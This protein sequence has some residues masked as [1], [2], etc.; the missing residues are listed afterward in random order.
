M[1]DQFT[2]PNGTAQ[3]VL[4]S[5]QVSWVNGV[6]TSKSAS[7]N[8]F[9]FTHKGLITENHTDTLFGANPAAAPALQNQFMSSL[10]NNGVHYLF[11][12]HDHIDN[13]AVITSPDGLSKVQ[14]ITAASNSYK[15]YVPQ[16]GANINDVKYDSPTRETPISQQM[17]TV[18]Y[19]LVNVDGPKVTVDFYSSPNG[20]N[21][22]CDLK[23][24][25][26]NLT[27]TKQETFG[28]SL[29]GKEFLVAAGASYTGINDSIAAGNGFLGTAMSFTAGVNGNNVN[30]YD[31]RGTVADVNTGWTSKGELGDAALRSDQLTMWGVSDLSNTSA[32][33]VTLE[34][35][36]TGDGPV[37]LMRKVNG[38]WQ[39]A[40]TGMGFD[41]AT[42]KAWANVSLSAIESGNFA[43]AAVPEP[44]TY[45]MFLAGLGLMG[46]VARRRIAAK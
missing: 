3:S 11:G 22:D 33:T 7:S 18:G 30:L 43:V 42:H 25:P 35:S 16:T 41:A 31:G 46:F 10:S 5:T 21:G 12:G 40:G 44:E 39:D 15:F 6:L 14:D 29:N 23:A 8:A 26:A 37:R 45:A 20:C 13:R 19:Y 17:F 4:D 34:M 24:L 38:V 32:N 28:Y 1:M 9:V 36:Y 2:R 27:Y